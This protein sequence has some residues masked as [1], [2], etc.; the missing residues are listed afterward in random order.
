MESI[1]NLSLS[2][3][4]CVR[5]CYLLINDLDAAPINTTYATHLH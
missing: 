4:V 2:M 5:A 3:C 1:V